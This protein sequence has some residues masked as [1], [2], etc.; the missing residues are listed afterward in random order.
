MPQFARRNVANTPGAGPGVM[1]LDGL[2]M[3][4]LSGPTGAPSVSA[5]HAARVVS[6][7]VPANRRISLMMA[8][9]GP[10][11]GWRTPMPAHVID[12]PLHS[13]LRLKD[14]CPQVP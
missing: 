1:V 5:L 10:P 8:A 12:T 3:N 9:A 11:G 4:S 13:G 14:M 6:V 7:I 2:A